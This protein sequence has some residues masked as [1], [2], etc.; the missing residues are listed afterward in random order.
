[1][2]TLPITLAVLFAA[3][4]HAAWNALV[5]RGADPLVELALVTLGASVI[6]LPRISG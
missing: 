4:L 5:K 2:L 3:L 1:M 6:A